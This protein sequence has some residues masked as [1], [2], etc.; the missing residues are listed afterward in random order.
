MTEW[1]MDMKT[2]DEAVIAAPPDVVFDAVTDLSTYGEWWAGI[3]TEPLGSQTRLAP[4]VRFRFT[5]MRPDGVVAMTWV[6]EVES[7]VPEQRID[8]RYVEGDLVGPVGWEFETA[9]GGTRTAYVYRGVN[10]TNANA[11]SGF[12]QHGLRIHNQAMQATLDGLQRFVGP[13][14]LVGDAFVGGR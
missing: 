2:R 12:E 7:L 1:N 9:K 4:G 6:I 11:A 3:I 10:P 14:N 13:K 5:G 8:L